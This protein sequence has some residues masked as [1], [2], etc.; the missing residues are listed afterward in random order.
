MHDFHYGGVMKQWMTY[1]DLIKE[2]FY[3][4]SLEKVRRNKDGY[5]RRYFKHDLVKGWISDSSYE[6]VSVPIIRS[7]IGMHQIK[8]ILSNQPLLPNHEIDHI[9]G[10]RRNNS[11][12][13]LRLVTSVINSKNRKKRSDNT[14]G[15]TGIRW[16]DY[17]NHYIIRRTIHGKRI[18]LSR[19][20]LGE[21]IKVLQELTLKDTSY[22]HRHGK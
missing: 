15:I 13:N 3:L 10:N 16:S 12:N 21:A 4:D 7:I 17:H 20:N 11:L 18:S 22:T 6:M 2:Y 19:K 1:A 9:D 14:S 8:Y 5:L